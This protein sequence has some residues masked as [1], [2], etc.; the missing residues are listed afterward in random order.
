[1]IAPISNGITQEYVGFQINTDRT[2]DFTG[3]VHALDGLEVRGFFANNNA[4][5]TTLQVNQNTY[6]VGN[7]FLD[8]V[9]INDIYQRRPWVSI[10]VDYSTFLQRISTITQRGQ[11]TATVSLQRNG[12]LVGFDAHPHNDTYVI[13]ATLIGSNGFIFQGASTNTTCF[14]STALSNGVFTPISFSLTIF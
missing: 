1:M 11:K 4:Y 6:F 2:A 3:K 13:S 10:R 9:N 7:V 8:N 14:I 12:Y 5:I